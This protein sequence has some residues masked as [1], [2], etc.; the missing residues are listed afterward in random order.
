MPVR[1]LYAQNWKPIL[2]N[3]VALAAINVVGLV[4]FVIIILIPFGMLALMT[5]NEGLKMFWL[6]LAIAF[7]YG[8][9]LAFINPFCLIS[10]IIT[11]NRAIDGQEPNANWEQ[12][13]E[14]VSEKFRELK[15]KAVNAMA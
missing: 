6:F 3:A 11:Y 14:Q 2:S 15:T 12:K 5:S 10:T 8:L 13:L 9:K 7:G 4:V 1:V